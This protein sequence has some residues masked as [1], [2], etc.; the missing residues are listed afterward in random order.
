MYSSDSSL[1]HLYYVIIISRSSSYINTCLNLVDEKRS[2]QPIWIPN[3]IA[4][5]SSNELLAGVALA[6][7]GF[8]VS[9]I[10][11]KADLA[12]SGTKR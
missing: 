10:I 8:Q 1:R 7:D 3:D 5:V 6:K 4:P 12:A 2:G 9:N 11:W